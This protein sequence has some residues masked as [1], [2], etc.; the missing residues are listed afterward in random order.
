VPAERWIDALR[1]AVRAELPAAASLRHD[2][3]RH[4][5]LS[6]SEAAT[7]ERVRR[8]LGPL[9]GHPVAGTGLLARI[10]R[11]D[12]PAVAV[13]AELDALP[14]T[15]TTGVPWSAS[16]PHMHACGHDVHLAALTALCRAMSRVDTEVPA[17][18]LAVFQP[19]EEADPSGALD[20]MSSPEWTRHEV[21]AVI[22]AHVQPLLGPGIVAATPGPINAAVCNIG[23]TVTGSGGHAAYPHVTQDPVLAI[24]EIVLSLQQVVSRRI[25][26]VHAAVLSIGELRAGTAPGVI[27]PSAYAAGTLR[28]LDPADMVTL[29][30]AA[31]EVTHA[32]ARA[33]RCAASVSFEPGEPVLANDERL[34]ADTRELLT[35]FGV[36]LAQ[37]LRSCGA[38][39]FSYY[40]QAHPGLMMFVG[41]KNIGQFGAVSLHQPTFCPADDAIAD[42]AEALIAGFGSA[43]RLQ[44][45]RG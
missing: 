6:G 30:D 3:H 13:R 23:I 8:A 43:T 12:G 44:T 29:R 40:A 33:H 9:T 20:V 5:E 26:P 41:T 42:V 28:A 39:D 21:Q 15:E 32:I 16:G 35:R 37:D 1:A 25:S 34:A 4:P 14:V 11:Q 38:D 27:P 2:L 18:M 17:A 19:R 7:A 31:T 24:S 10:G 22:G 36:T 45:P